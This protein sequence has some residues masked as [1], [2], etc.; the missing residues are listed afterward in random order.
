MTSQ[1][2]WRSKDSRAPAGQTVGSRAIIQSSPGTNTWLGW[3]NANSFMWSYL[4]SVL[5]WGNGQLNGLLVAISWSDHMP[6]VL[7]LTFH[8]LEKSCGVWLTF[9]QGKAKILAFRKKAQMKMVLEKILF[10]MHRPSGM[11]HEKLFAD[12]NLWK[13]DLS[14]YD[15][16]LEKLSLQ[17]VLEI[18]HCDRCPTFSV[19]QTLIIMWKK[20]LYR[21]GKKSPWSPLVMCNI[22]F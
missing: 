15:H 18:C 11:H 20:F 14:I 8:V 16:V 13:R 1:W 7:I 9:H 6:H 4:G 10:S 17:K 5:G 19:L 22:N 3:S 21:Y 2:S 12:S